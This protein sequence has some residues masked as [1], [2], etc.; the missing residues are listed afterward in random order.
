MTTVDGHDSGGN[1][2][3]CLLWPRLAVAL[4]SPESQIFKL[5]LDSWTLWVHRC[6][7]VSTVAEVKGIVNE[8]SFAGARNANSLSW[9]LLSHSQ[10]WVPSRGW[11]LPDCRPGIHESHGSR[12]GI[13]A[14]PFS[15]FE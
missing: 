11:A 13:L 15:R 2:G 4:W 5:L 10:R 8:M 12:P 1:K 6:G 3:E 9:A 14:H 7:K